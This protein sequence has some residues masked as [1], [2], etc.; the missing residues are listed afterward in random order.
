MLSTTLGVTCSSL[1]AATDLAQ[2]SSCYT[3]RPVVSCSPLCSKSGGSLHLVLLP[4]F[5]SNLLQ[6][7]IPHLRASLFSS[8]QRWALLPS[9][10]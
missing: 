4:P 5:L 1:T 6:L 2:I 7:G 10:P 9:P 3:E 8:Q